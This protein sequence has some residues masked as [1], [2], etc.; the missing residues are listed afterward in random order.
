[1]EI[2]EA[3]FDFSY[4]DGEPFSHHIGTRTVRGLFWKPDKQKDKHVTVIHVH[5]LGDWLTRNKDLFKV[6]VD[7]GFTVM[8]TDHLGHGKSDGKHCD[9]SVYEIVEETILNVEASKEMFPYNKIFLWGHSL[10]GLSV[11]YAAL[12]R[13]V[14]IREKVRGIICES[15]WLST[16]DK[17]NPISLWESLFLYFSN[18]FYPDMQIKM[19]IPENTNEMPDRFIALTKSSP[20]NFNTITP[21]MM[22]SVFQAITDVR[23]M[24]QVW[25]KGIKTFMGFGKKDDNLCLDE[26][27][28]YYNDMLAQSATGDVI[29]RLYDGYHN[30]TKCNARSEFLTDVFEFIENNL[31][32][33]E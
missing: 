4:D 1:M 19:D 14:V 13:T 9:T 10:G 8:G 31:K 32:P 22:I 2:S 16:T 28:P 7:R 20:Y 5:G 27:M 6:L 12:F 30:L 25:P 26:M 3:F 29:I 33:R 24:S 17:Q 23:S 18:F 15:P 21:K 11:M